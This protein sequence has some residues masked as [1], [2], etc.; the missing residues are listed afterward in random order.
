MYVYM[1]VCV[2]C[3]QSAHTATIRQ[4]QYYRRRGEAIFLSDSLKTF[5]GRT[6]ERLCTNSLNVTNLKMLISNLKRRGLLEG[7]R[8]RGLGGTSWEDS[9]V[10]GVVR[11]ERRGEETFAWLLRKE[12]K[13]R[14]VVN[15]LYHRGDASAFTRP[16]IDWR[17]KEKRTSSQGRFCVQSDE[18]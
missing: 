12:R 7:Q 4:Q 10:N 3:L 13:G 15:R 14:S 17:V 2:Y 8:R 16:G 1:C 11:E 6:Q 5:I 18:T 9:V